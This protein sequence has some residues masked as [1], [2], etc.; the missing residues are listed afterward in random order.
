[1]NKQSKLTKGIRKFLVLYALSDLHG[2]E[3]EEREV[4]RRVSEI[5][6]VSHRQ[7]RRYAS[8]ASKMPM[9]KIVLLVNFL[10]PY[11]PEITEETIK[12]IF[13]PNE[14][15]AQTGREA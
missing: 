12:E 4:V 1:M 7:V 8:G 13:Y 14:G 11:V 2:C 3:L 9:A 5:L 10:M 6:E 15:E